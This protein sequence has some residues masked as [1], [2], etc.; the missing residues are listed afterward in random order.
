MKAKK[1]M[2]QCQPMQNE[3]NQDV[4]EQL[5]EKQLDKREMSVPGELTK[6]LVVSKVGSKNLLDRRPL[7]SGD[8]VMFKAKISFF[9][10]NHRIFK[11]K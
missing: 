5:E 2:K 10:I 9:N 7:W 4:K 3:G 8:Y 1:K 6:Y 11:V